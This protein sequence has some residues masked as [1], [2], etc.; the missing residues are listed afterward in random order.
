MARP[1]YHILGG[2]GGADAV[3]PALDDEAIVNINAIGGWPRYS[4]PYDPY[5]NQLLRAL[6]TDYPIPAPPVRPG[7]PA[8][9]APGAVPPEIRAEQARITAAMQDFIRGP[10][11]ADWSNR[12]IR[13]LVNN[14]MANPAV[15]ATFVG[16][17][18]AFTAALLA[19]V[20]NP[21]NQ[22]AIRPPPAAALPLATFAGIV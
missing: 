6:T 2:P 22:I 7:A 5:Y 20:R 13:N 3:G 18:P 11:L 19:F 14:A 12:W 16:P 1:V 8:A 9:P 4:I 17:M 10:I 15:Q 21:A